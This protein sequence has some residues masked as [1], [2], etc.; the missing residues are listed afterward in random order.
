MKKFFYISILLCSIFAELNASSISST[1]TTGNWSSTASWV[2]GVIPGI[3]DSVIIVNGANIT[4][5]ANSVIYKITINTGGTLNL[6]DKTLTL[7][8]NTNLGG[9]CGIW[10]TLNLN[11]GTIQ[12]T[13]NFINYGTF[14]CGTGTVIFNGTDGQGIEGNTVSTFYN[15]R[16][17]NTNAAVGKGLSAHPV[18]TIIKGNFIADGTFNRNSQGNPNS[19]VT[20]DGNTQLSGA[21]SFYLNHVVINAGATVNAG[22]KTI[23]LYGNWTSNGTFICGTGTISV[24]YDTYSSC[25]PI[26]QTIYQ[27]F[28]DLNPF[29]NIDV[30]KTSGSASPITGVDNTLGNLYVSNNFTV[31]NGTW[32][33]NGVKRLY[34]KGNFVVNP[35]ATYTASTGRVLMTGTNATTPQT[36]SCNSSLYKVTID[37][38]GA[39][40]KLATN[41]NI[42]FEL[43]LTNGILYTRNSTLNYELYVSNNDP[44]SIPVG[45]SA[46]SY[47]AG[48]L[49]RAI[50]APNNYTYPVGVSNSILHKYRPLVLNLTAA[51]GASTISVNQDSTQ[52]S[53]TYYSSY[54]TKI[55][56]DAGNPTGTVNFSYNLS[57]D[58]QSGMTECSISAL[59]GTQPP[60]TNWNYVLNTTIPAAGANNGHLT[61]TLPASFS[62]YAF[63]LGEPEPVAINPTICDG[64]TATLNITSPTGYGTFNWYSTQT[65][66]SAILTNNTTFT[67]PVLFDT[68]TYYITHNNSICEGHRYPVII[69]VNNIPTSSFTAQNPIC[70]GTAA[71]ITYNGTATAAGTYSWNFGGATANPGT[72]QG[73]QLLTGTAGQTY[74]VS[75]QVTQNGCTSTVSNGTVTIPTALTIGL[76]NTNATCG[77]NNGS[78]TVNP[79]GGW[80]NYSYIWSNSQTNTTATNL[81][82]GT[83]NV[84]VT[85]QNGCSKTG[86][87]TVSDLGA[88]V[89]NSNII[90]NISC[91]NGHDGKAQVTATGTGVLTYTWSNGVTG[92]GNGSVSSQIDTLSAGNYQITISD[93]NSCQSVTNI[94]I[95]QPSAITASFTINN[96]ICYGQNNG[97]INTTVS[98][99]TVAGNYTYSWLQGSSQQNLINMAAGT[100]YV[101]IKDD[102][103][104][105]LSQQVT[106]TQPDSISISISETNISCFGEN[107]GILS[108]TVIGGTQPYT[109]VWSNS[110]TD[111]IAENLTGGNYFLIVTDNNGCNNIKYDTLLQPTHV[112]VLISSLPVTCYGY[113][114]GMVGINV[115]GG[116]SPY[117]FLWDNNATTEDL[118]AVA[119]GSYW[120]TITD[121]N[122]CTAVASESVI[123]PNPLIT[124][125]SIV[126]VHCFNGTNG[127]V[128]ANVQGGVTPYNYS[129]S[130]GISAANNLNIS[131]GIY[132]L[133]ITDFN[134][135]SD[136][137]IAIVDQP[138]AIAIT[139][140]TSNVKCKNNSNGSID[141]QV[142]GGI[143]PYNYTWNN[144]AISQDIYGLAPGIYIV[145]I[146]DGN[147]CTS[148]QSYQISEPDSLDIS[149]INIGTLCTNDSIGSITTTVTG[150]TPA[151]TYYWS[152]GA[153][154]SSLTSLTHG[155]YIL[156]VSDANLCTLTKT[157]NLEGSPPVS[158]NIVTTLNNVLAEV[159]GGSSPYTYSW[160]NGNTNSTF[161]ISQSG[162]YIVTITDNFGCTATADSDIIIEFEIPTVFTPNNDLVNDT[163][164]I[165]GIETYSDVTIE[166]FNRWGDILFK[167]N[168]AGLEYKNRSTQWDGQFKGKDLPMGAYLFIVNLHNNEKAITGAVS[169]V[170]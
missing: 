43:Q 82:S 170:R 16:S 165:K 139:G 64:N 23:Y 127:S 70:N 81:T 48:N 27:A 38:S 135:C 32:N 121:D 30:S 120:V 136:T 124:S 69:N 158:V 61:S 51:G 141:L 28:P 87:T 118:N 42:T 5:N 112:D 149:T 25:Q 97:T 21:Y 147:N 24:K 108:A 34:V 55:L 74:N 138:Q 164:E 151:Y 152:N 33:A 109:Y 122:G 104:C 1:I 66:G 40:V 123:E 77:N 11:T 114:D 76:T 78:A 53:G 125:L 91:N 131:S 133:T 150:G 159:N 106:I 19:T 59:R 132:S 148:S 54:W 37:N 169:I 155:I 85:D 98:G 126:S 3:N 154:T 22:S 72:G 57:S 113:T 58:F 75:L 12:Q 161:T 130:N 52:N 26:S 86:S 44:I 29:W 101:T 128:S 36:L 2:G 145:T 68:T 111:A 67:T 110:D 142:T 115:T 88:P 143:Q 99:G 117:T 9:N 129:W 107:D 41:I 93:Q 20:F 96:A 7:Q 65:G 73:P 14:N 31:S 156:T 137:L 45:Y 116:T 84:T 102:N 35:V 15:L 95:T 8:G 162:S 83:Y 146:N 49:K 89:L 94:N 63:M 168:G 6:S 39:G 160:N 13:G 92:N 18:N 17:M 134:S 62:P 167:F 60:A 140:T 100:Y 103:N 163:W 47:I 46:S 4:L 50:V 71:N 119:S 10:G 166:I 144:S 157:I 56:P 105:S 79:T 153:N 80:G 90:N